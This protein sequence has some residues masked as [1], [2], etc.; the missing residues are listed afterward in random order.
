MKLAITLFASILLCAS[1]HAEDAAVG[2]AKTG[3]DA[4]PP[5]ESKLQTEARPKASIEK[6]PFVFG[7][8]LTDVAH[9]DKL[10]H[11]LS[12]RQPA[13]P[14]RDAQHIHFDEKTGRAKGV[15]L[16]SIGF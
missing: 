15:V 13:N 10:S 2:N 9:A 11:L 7:G 14:K 8:F 1:I 3:P 16:F 12:L 6:K 4:N 5:G